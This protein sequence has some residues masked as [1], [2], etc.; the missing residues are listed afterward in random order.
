MGK[1]GG[2]LNDS[3]LKKDTVYCPSCGY[4]IVAFRNADGAIKKQ[5][6]KCKA[7]IYSVV[8]NKELAVKAVNS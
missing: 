4:K 2:K 8:K 5:C 1:G 7:V 6:K 3:S